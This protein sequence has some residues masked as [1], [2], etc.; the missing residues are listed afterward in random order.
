MCKPAAKEHDTIVATDTHL[1]NGTPT[2]LP[3]DGI[4]DGNL[5]PNVI[6]EHRPAAMVDSTATNTPPHLA[7]P[8]MTFDN[9]PSNRGVIVQGSA[10]VLINQRHAARDGDTANTC[11][12][13]V[14]APKGA[15]VASSTVLMGG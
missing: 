3:F 10:T 2:L 15:V 8:G 11:N 5:S 6:V 7:P 1:L 4:I 13:P 12:D 9:P 14:D